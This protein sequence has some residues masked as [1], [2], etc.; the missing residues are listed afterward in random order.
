MEDEL[1]DLLF[2]IANL[3]RYLS[4]NPEEALRK[5]I[6]RFQK[7]FSFVEDELF[8]QGVTMQNATLVEMDALWEKAKCAEHESKI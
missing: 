4:L 2:A 8:H 7:R 3:G 6:N 5:T 1:G